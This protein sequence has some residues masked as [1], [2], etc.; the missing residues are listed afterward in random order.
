MSRLSFLTHLVGGAAA[1]GVALGT[2]HQWLGL[3]A[4]FARLLP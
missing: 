4:R 3:L 2:I 1:T